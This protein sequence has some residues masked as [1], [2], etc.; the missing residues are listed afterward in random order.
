MRKTVTLILAVALV[1]SLAAGCGSSKPSA[2]APPSGSESQ[3][4]PEQSGTLEESPLNPEAESPA[5]PIPESSEDL[6]SYTMPLS[7]KPAELSFWYIFPSVFLTFMDGPEDFQ[8]YAKMEELSNVHLEWITTPAETSDSSFN[9]MVASGAYQDLLYNAA[10]KYSL[11]LDAAVENG[12]VM[13]LEDLVEE[14]MPCYSYWRSQDESFAKNTVTDQHLAAI[15]GYCPHEI[16]ETGPYVRQD[17]LDEL[18]MDMPVTYDDYYELLKAFKSEYGGSAPFAGLG[19]NGLIMGGNYL[20]AGF[21]VAACIGINSSTLPFYVVDNEV[22]FGPTQDEF[23]SYLTMMN[24]W[25]SEGLIDPDFASSDNAGWASRLVSSGDTVFWYAQLA[26]MPAYNEEMTGIDGINVVGSY[27][28]VLEEGSVNH[29]RPYQ[30]GTS[31]NS[32]SIST[33]CENIELACHW[34][35]YWF[36]EEGSQLGTWGVEGQGYDISSDGKKIISENV[37][38]NPDGIPMGI[39][40]TKYTLNRDV[41][42]KDGTRDDQLYTQAQ[43]D[44]MERWSAADIAYTFPSMASM[45]IDESE[46][47]GLL[48]SDVKTYLDECIPL[49]I[50]GD[51]PLSEFDV[52]VETLEGSLNVNRLVEIMQASYDRYI[53]R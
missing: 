44:A 43:L 23:L 16:I 34:L 22:K 40:N 41:Y 12:V 39:A 50:N 9:I 31:F 10:D 35:D 15:W 32:I 25:Y 27:D 8:A 1:L 36:S 11:G 52:F 6:Y 21:G 3:T 2:S 26:N 29:F 24:S 14:Y 28:P 42:Y 47:Y 51:M 18:N 38:H 48:I 13:P 45:T 4:T 19:S 20:T 49:F 17:V 7:D 53:N 37:L 33:A 46:E 5:E 30:T